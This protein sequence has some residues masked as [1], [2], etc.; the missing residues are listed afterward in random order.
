MDGIDMRTIPKEFTSVLNISSDETDFVN[1]SG[2]SQL[3]NC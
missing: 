3:P 2:S 1:D